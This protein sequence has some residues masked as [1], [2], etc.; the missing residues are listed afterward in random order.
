M[1]ARLVCLFTGLA[2]AALALCLPTR[3]VSQTNLPALSSAVLL[4]EDANYRLGKRYPASITWRT[5]QI[6][7]NSEKRLAVDARIEIPERLLTT[8]VSF[9]PTDNSA[10]SAIIIFATA[11][12]F[13]YGGAST[14]GG[15]VMKLQE[16]STGAPLMGRPRKIA[17][18]S[19]EIPLSDTDRERQQNAALLNA[20]AWFDIPVLFTDGKRAIVSFEKGQ[21]GEQA[22]SQ[23]FLS[24]K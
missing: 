15:V 4:E 13:A 21:A 19:F 18:N 8:Y 10:L 16:A 9:G 14:V 22:F 7:T 2:A 12:G 23:G 17:T 6:S 5:R 20:N 1:S 3:A 11:P 24:W